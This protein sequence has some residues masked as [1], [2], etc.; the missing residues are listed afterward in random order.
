MPCAVK[1]ASETKQGRLL[2]SYSSVINET[3][4]IPMSY[5]L[6]ISRYVISK[7]LS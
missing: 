7:I 2:T 6:R 3:Q 5:L 4:I 1:R